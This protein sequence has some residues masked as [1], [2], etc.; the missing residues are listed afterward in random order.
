[1]KEKHWI[2]YPAIPLTHVF[3]EFEDKRIRDRFVR[4]ASMRKYE[5]EEKNNKD[6]RSV[7]TRTKVRKEKIG[8]HQVC[9]QQKH[10]DTFALDKAES[11]KKERIFERTAS[12]QSRER[13][14]TQVLQIRRHWKRS[15][16]THWQMVDKKLVVA[17]VRSREIRMQRRINQVT[18][19]SHFETGTKKRWKERGKES[20]S[21][22]L[23]KKGKQNT[24]HHQKQKMQ[25]GRE[26]RCSSRH[27]R[28]NVTEWW[29]SRS[30]KKGRHRLLERW[31]RR[32]RQQQ[33]NLASKS[34]RR[35]TKNHVHCTAEKHE[36]NEL[37][38]T[39]G[40]ADQRTVPGRLGRDTD[41]WNMAPKQR[42]LGDTA[43]S[44]H[45]WVRPI[46]QQTLSRNTVEQKMEESGQ[47]GAMR[48]RT[49]GSDVDF[50]QQAPDSADECVH[51]TQWI[52]RSPCREGLQNNYQDDRRRKRHENHWRW[53]Q[54][55]AWSRRRIGV[56]CCWTLHFEQR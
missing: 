27:W 16:R 9:H 41:L 19:S 5:M 35:V 10:R 28:H 34:K 25:E 23:Q 40:W 18:T 6:I 30:G 43:R 24:I 21:Y 48:E 49:C 13:W 46:H 8:I 50:D 11:G 17:T 51:A 53:L 3:V 33:Q 14:I 55:R 22:L 15:T 12:G 39:T 52:C 32:Q 54:C 26:G 47:M 20:N 4:S 31:R 7:R 1:M 38:R 45:G 29:K 37:E 42:G 2:D 44:H 56:V 36:V